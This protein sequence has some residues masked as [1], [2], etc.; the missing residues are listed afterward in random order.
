MRLQHVSVG[1]HLSVLRREIMPLART[2]M[3]TITAAQGIAI[4][5]KTDPV[6]PSDHIR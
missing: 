3:K 5:A 6:T 1:A 2:S 4:T